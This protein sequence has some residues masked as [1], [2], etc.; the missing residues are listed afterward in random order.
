MNGLETLR[1]MRAN[2]Y[3][4]PVVL[5]SGRASLEPSDAVESGAEAFLPKPMDPSVLM[6]LAQ[7]MV[8]NE[9]GG[10]TVS[11]TTMTAATRE[12][13]LV[14]KSPDMLEVSKSIAHVARTDAPVLVAATS[15]HVMSRSV[16]MPSTRP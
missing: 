7:R 1:A 13:R 8:S 6:A 4:N 15:R 11:L 10:D 9:L 5:T 2:G 14:G 16:I 12:M 3:T